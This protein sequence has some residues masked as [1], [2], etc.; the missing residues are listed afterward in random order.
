MTK[1]MLKKSFENIDNRASIPEGIT[2]RKDQYWDIIEKSPTKNPTR[3]LVGIAVSLAL[4]FV[5]LFWYQRESAVSPSIH[6]LSEVSL[7]TQKNIML[8]KFKAKPNPKLDIIPEV[9]SRTPARRHAQGPLELP[10]NSPEKAENA[11]SQKATKLLVLPTLETSNSEQDASKEKPLS[12]S[13]NALKKALANTKKEGP[14]EEKMVVEKL[15]FE[16][17]IQARRNYFLEKNSEKKSKKDN[18]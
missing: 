5:A 4:L 16:Q 17:T 6:V 2:F 3:N 8:D 18:E 7:S 9:D 14:K 10:S 12:P 1:T 11:Q 15:T 13:A